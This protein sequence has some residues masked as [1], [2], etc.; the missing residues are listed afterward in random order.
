MSAPHP[1]DVPS[2]VGPAPGPAVAEDQETVNGPG[3]ARARRRLLPVV[4]VLVVVLIGVPAGVT[5]ALIG[6][7]G[8]STTTAGG[9]AGAGTGQPISEFPV[10]E[11]GAPVELAGTTLTDDFLDVADLRGQ[12]VVINV[13]GSWCPPCRKEAPILAKLSRG[14]ADQG[15]AFVGVDVKDNRAAALAFE[16]TY[17][18]TYPS[19]EDPDGR[20]VLALSQYVPASAVPVTLVLDAEGRVAARVLGAV[21]EATLRALLDST[22]REAA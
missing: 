1:P 4:A 16:R 6:G 3:D 7:D 19:I 22:L 9:A 12:V 5:W 2:E 20:A 13:W 8:G 21:R 10:A 17:G 18:I 11:R 15:V 14:Y